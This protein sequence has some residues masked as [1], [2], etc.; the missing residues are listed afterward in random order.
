TTYNG[1][2]GSTTIPNAITIKGPVA[3][4]YPEGNCATPFSYIFHGDIKDATSW[5]WNFGDGTVINTSTDTA[6]SH[7]YATTGDYIVIL[8]AQN[9]TTGCPAY[10]DSAVVRVRDIKSNFTSDSIVCV[11]AGVVYDGSLSQDA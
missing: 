9:N 7:T 5:I 8:T 10:D 11:G 2:P 1:C 3:R 4:F 6:P